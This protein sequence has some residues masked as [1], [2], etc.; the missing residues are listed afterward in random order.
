MNPIPNLYRLY[1]FQIV[2]QKE[3]FSAAAVAL[4]TSQ[5]N[6]SK[7]VHLLEIELGVDLLE[8]RGSR[9]YLTDAGR[10]VL[11]TTERI[12]DH[13]G[14]M[15]QTLQ[16]LQGS[17]RGVLRLAACG[18]P[19]LYLLPAMLPG[20]RQR[21]PQIEISLVIGN[22][23]EVID[24]VSQNQVEIGFIEEHR[25]VPGIQ[26]QPWITDQLVLVADSRNPLAKQGKISIH[27]LKSQVFLMR[28]DGSAT[29]EQMIRTLKAAELDSV[30]Q[31]ELSG[32]EGIKRGVVAGLGISLVSRR[33]IEAEQKNG[34]ITILNV[35]ELFID[36]TIV[37]ATQKEK[38]LSVAAL[39]FL[40]QIHRSVGSILT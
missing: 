33:T 35:S 27:E 40:G 1:V 31:M 29:R 5:P 2:A 9:V 4:H 25:P 21:Y 30:R 17:E 19:G 12:L 10:A 38:R 24:K 13:I 3:S 22:Y 23:R 15:H 37:I 20:F 16:D 39:T 36:R 18:M 32:C 11:K 8:R 28:E 26:M 6:I 34:T 7:H 14:A